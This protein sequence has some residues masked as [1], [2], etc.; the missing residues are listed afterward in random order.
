MLED[1]RDSSDSGERD[2]LVQADA[3]V[4]AK[5]RRSVLKCQSLQAELSKSIEN[6]NLLDAT[7]HERAQ[8][9][10]Q[11]SCD[12]QQRLA[13]LD[14]LRGR[15]RQGES[16]IAQLAEAIARKDQDIAA[17]SADCSSL[18]AS[19]QS[20]TAEL[21]RVQALER[22]LSAEREASEALQS[23]AASLSATA[24][25]READLHRLRLSLIARDAGA[26]PALLALPDH[27]AVGALRELSG[28]L[29]SLRTAHAPEAVV[30][31]NRARLRFAEAKSAAIA[32]VTAQAEAIRAERA[33]LEAER[34][35]TEAA[36]LK[37]E[38]DEAGLTALER[39]RAG[40]E[41]NGECDCPA[42]RRE[43]AAVDARVNAIG[44]EIARLEGLR[45][46]RAAEFANADAAQAQL[47]ELARK[48]EV[49]AR[50]CARMAAR[51][52]AV[53]RAR[54]RDEFEDERAEIQR[55][56]EMKG[57]AGGDR[58]EREAAVQAEGERLL[59]K[60]AELDEKRA[61]IERAEEA[62]AG[63]RAVYEKQ[64][65]ELAMKRR[66]NGGGDTA[67][68][69][70]LKAILLQFFLQEPVKREELVPVL[71]TRVGCTPDEVTVALRKW[72]ESQRLIGGTFWPF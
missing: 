11:L 5:L 69:N 67:K 39:G 33:G 44:G 56:V 37:L 64:R 8:V 22:Q 52:A 53:A 62:H 31:Y 16:G 6:A 59:A 36:L 50:D 20:L 40:E 9:I 71:L 35:E 63:R 72:S 2:L 54:A 21:A 17:L 10:F 23:S 32:R 48:N 1:D 57:Q 49:L 12:S 14:D 7:V 43:R 29:R 13:S 18:Q 38:A 65:A 55:L 51:A 24:A 68:A 41:R 4:R 15:I 34:A 58:G 27:P 25:A 47:A 28:E 26:P 61:E 66:P 3:K 19:A 60:E 46:S 30:A 42:M 45:L 70:D